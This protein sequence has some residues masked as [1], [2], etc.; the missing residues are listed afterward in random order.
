[1]DPI[2][3]GLASHLH[4]DPHPS[5]CILTPGTP[6]TV[7]DSEGVSGAGCSLRRK[8]RSEGGVPSSLH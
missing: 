8:R 2:P 3:S 6:L 4:S 7:K 5:K 1:M